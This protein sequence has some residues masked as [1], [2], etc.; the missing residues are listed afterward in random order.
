MKEDAKPKTMEDAI[1]Q[2]NLWCGFCLLVFSVFISSFIVS[3]WF[4]RRCWDGKDPVLTEDYQ[5][6]LNCCKAVLNVVW[7]ALVVYFIQ[8][9]YPPSLC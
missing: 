8:T 2:I 4:D 7:P 1:G 9:E 5:S 6:P 3:L